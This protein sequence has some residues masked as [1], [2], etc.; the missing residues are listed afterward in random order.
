MTAAVP[1]MLRRSLLFSFQS[2]TLFFCRAR[3]TGTCFLKRL[4]HSS[5]LSSSVGGGGIAIPTDSF[6]P[7]RINYTF[8]PETVERA[9]KYDL[10][11]LSRR[12]ATVEPGCFTGERRGYENFSVLRIWNSCNSSGF[13]FLEM[14]P[15]NAT[16]PGFE[17][18]G[19]SSYRIFNSSSAT[20]NYTGEFEEEDWQRPV[21][22]T[23]RTVPLELYLES[24]ELNESSGRGKL[25]VRLN[26][27]ADCRLEVS[28][29]TR[30]FNGTRDVET[31]LNLEPGMNEILLECGNQ[32][33]SFT[34]L[35][36]EQEQPRDGFE[37]PEVDLRPLVL[38]A[39]AAMLLGGAVYSRQM[40]LESLMG[41][42]AWALESAFFYTL[43]NGRPGLAITAYTWLHKLSG[44]SAREMLDAGVKLD[45]SVYLY[46]ALDTLAGSEQALDIEN[47]TELVLNAVEFVEDNPSTRAG[48]KI[49][50]KLEEIDY[51]R[52]NV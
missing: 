35:L 46:L 1:T 20:V 31:D 12:N 14:L 17:R 38:P 4:N 21:P 18:V 6:D 22:F 23:L 5:P 2:T 8:D 42:V 45:R 34:E 39:L 16:A 7:Y 44:T 51:S 33:L 52:F 9:G 24:M 25:D 32:S 41:G 48:R 37:I 28:N 3:N 29:T 13:G 27:R 11:E 43:D 19:N 47:E 10:S 36:E 30:F 15:A 40:I 50:S 26:R 49:A